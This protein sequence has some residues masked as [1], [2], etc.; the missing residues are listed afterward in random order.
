[1]NKYLNYKL[2]EAVVNSKDVK[3]PETMVL[4]YKRMTEFKNKNSKFSYLF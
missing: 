4:A 1:M 2:L 3:V